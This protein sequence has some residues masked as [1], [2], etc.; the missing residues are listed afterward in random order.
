MDSLKKG[1]QECEGEESGDG[2]PLPS[3]LGH[4]LHLIGIMTSWRGGALVGSGR[5]RLVQVRNGGLSLG[6]GQV[7]SVSC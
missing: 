1:W 5:E 6:N 2:V 3:Q 4:T 7:K